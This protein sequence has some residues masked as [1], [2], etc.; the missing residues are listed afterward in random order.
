MATLNDT[1]ALNA[2]NEKDYIN[3]LYDNNTDAAK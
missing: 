2:L 3:K 1:S